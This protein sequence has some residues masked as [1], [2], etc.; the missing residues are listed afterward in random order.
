ML[1]EDKY[2]NELTKDELWNRYCGYFDLSLGEF[3]EIQHHLLMDEVNMVADSILG[4][5]IMGN[6]PS[7]IE[8]FRE[9]VGLTSY[10]DY[11]PYLSERQE[12]A[13]AVKPYSWCHSSGRGGEF[14]WIPY[15]AD[16]LEVASR[17]FIS[18]VILST[19]NQKGDIRIKPGERVV[20][21][22]PPRPYLSGMLAN[23]A[24]SVFTIRMI[25]P[26][27]EAEKME[28]QEAIQKGFAMA[29]RTGVDEMAS[30]SSVMV[31]VGERMTEQAQ[32]IQFSPAMLQPKLLYTLGRAWLRS[33]I[34]KRAM[35]PK[36]IWRPKGIIAGG[37]D[38]S[39]YKNDVA[40]YWGKIPFE[41]YGATEAVSL[42]IQNWNKK[43]LT[44]I[45]Y[46]AF[47]EFIPED[48][49]IKLREDVNYQPKTLLLNEVEEGKIYELVITNFYGMPLIRY[50][51]RD[52]IKIVALNDDETGVA[53]PQFV[54]HARV[55]ETVDLA[56]LA[57]LTERV[58]WQAI[59]NTEVKFED[60]SACKEYDQNK[61]HLRVYIE[62]KEERET[63][64]L[65]RLID[66]HLREVDL[67]Y[68][69]VGKYLNMQPV[70]VSVLSPGTFDRYYQEKV[71]E[72][73]DMAHLKPP[74]INASDEEIERL[75]RLN[76]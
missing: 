21:H 52:L 60:W 54:F 40:Y 61:T 57:R 7:S 4:R 25:P 46:F 59:A 75:L 35:L 43:W 55:G 9:T 27:E 31:K 13:L 38:T 26:Q 34:E 32:G 30:I 48:E 67:D 45:P 73:A 65:E 28:F 50:R 18:N 8:E 71:S 24:S 37:T 56:G 2:F 41:M 5:K 68:R 10:E 70:K 36:D 72:G 44:F 22:I 20:M 3:M 17:L 58:I 33:K 66:E 15:T 51:L 29:L 76:T 47:L 42:G 64:E 69:D 1:Q 53:L 63:S 62:L 6:K 19:A 12:D 49:S 11:E 23:Y 16:A 74:H 39:I 14:K